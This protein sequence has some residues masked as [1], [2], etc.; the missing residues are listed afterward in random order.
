[1]SMAAGDLARRGISTVDAKLIFAGRKW[2]KR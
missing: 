2:Q 1:L